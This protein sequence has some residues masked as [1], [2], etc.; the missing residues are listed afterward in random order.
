MAAPSSTATWPRRP[1]SLGRDELAIL[2]VML[3]RGPQTPGELKARSDRM[4]PLGSLEDVDRVLEILSERGY[5][6]RIPRRP[7]QKEDRFEHLMGGEPEAAVAA[8]ALLPSPPAI[9]RESSTEDLAAR[10]AELESQVKELRQELAA[11][12]GQA[13]A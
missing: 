10:V 8:E 4:A 7:G 12:R 11:L 5:A 6:R 2:A 3:L 1:S 13:A 9:D